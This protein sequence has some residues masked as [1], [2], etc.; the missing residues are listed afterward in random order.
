LVWPD[1]SIGGASGRN[2]LLGVVAVQVACIGW[3]FA[4]SYTK[5][6]VTS[7]DVLGAAT[8]Q[9]LFGGVFLTLAGTLRGEWAHLSFS[10][11]TTV[12]LVYLVLAGSVIAF[13][14]YSYALKHLPIA[15]VSLYTYVNPVIAVALGIVLLNEPFDV[16]QLAAAGVIAAGMII[17]RPG[18]RA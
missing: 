9:M 3:S 8:L 15:V 7:G 13:V 12:S 16:R 2:I 4:S 18:K 17:V 1:L 5:R 14:A 10:M 11:P 6:H